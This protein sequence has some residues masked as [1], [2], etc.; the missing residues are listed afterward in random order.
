[1]QWPTSRPRS[2]ARRSSDTPRGRCSAGPPD[3]HGWRSLDWTA[4]WLGRPWD[5]PHWAE[6]PRMCSGRETPVP[7]QSWWS[8][9]PCPLKRL[10]HHLR[11]TNKYKTSSIKTMNNVQWTMYQW[12]SSI[13]TSSIRHQSQ[14]WASRYDS[15]D[16]LPKPDEMVE[17]DAWLCSVDE[18]LGESSSSVSSLS[19]GTSSAAG[20]RGGSLSSRDEPEMQMWSW[21]CA[22]A[23]GFDSDGTEGV[24][25]PTRSLQ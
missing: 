16:S 8:R 23:A 1:M 14:A 15:R 18:G 17:W 11:G 7:P 21:G 19:K 3:W 12:T 25:W 20:T 2:R 22:D 24:E 6:E 13:K 4:A 5:C 10:L 9:W